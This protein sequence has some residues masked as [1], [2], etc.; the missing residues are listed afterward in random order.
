MSRTRDTAAEAVPIDHG[1]LIDGFGELWGY[2]TYRPFDTFCGI[3]DAP[4]ILTPGEQKYLLEVKRVPVKMLQRGAVYCASCRSRRARMN[5]LKR[6]DGTKTA[7]D[8][9]AELAQLRSLEDDS[10]R[11]SHSRFERAAWPYPYLAR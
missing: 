11:L 4:V 9:R 7:P 5:E 1:K 2:A 6:I 10:R 8:V 3:C